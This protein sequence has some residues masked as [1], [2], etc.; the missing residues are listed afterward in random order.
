MEEIHKVAKSRELDYF[1]NR[2][3]IIIDFMLSKNDIDVMMLDYKRIIED[4]FRKG[5]LKRFKNT[6]K[7]YKRLGKG[8]SRKRNK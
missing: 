6:F 4:T 1:K 5:S 8:T 7:R 3:L 2:S